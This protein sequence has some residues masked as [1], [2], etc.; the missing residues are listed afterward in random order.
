MKDWKRPDSLPRL[1]QLIYKKI[2]PGII[3]QFQHC[4]TLTSRLS[5]KTACEG[6]IVWNKSNRVSYK[7]HSL[8]F[9]PAESLMPGEK[10][11]KCETTTKTTSPRVIGMALQ[12]QAGYLRM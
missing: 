5:T 8:S 1:T 3:L 2:K 6:P 12:V 10:P 9:I 4:V 11:E 7:G